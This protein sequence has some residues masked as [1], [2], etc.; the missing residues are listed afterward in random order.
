MRD[1]PTV[2]PRPLRVLLTM[3]GGPV[4]SRWTGVVMLLVEPG[5]RAPRLGVC[6]VCRKDFIR[7]GTRLGRDQYGGAG[8]DVAVGA[9][10]KGAHSASGK[11]PAL[12]AA[13]GRCSHTLNLALRRVE[14]I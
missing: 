8:A 1:S 11:Y 3:R 9:S 7:S 12:L 4:H 5:D 2:S 13:A 6:K 10:T 14:S